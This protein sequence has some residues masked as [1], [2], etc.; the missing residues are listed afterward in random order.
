MARS[1]RDKERRKQRLAITV[2]VIVILLVLAIPAYGYYASFV[3][4]PRELAGRVRD[5]RY[6]MGDLVKQIRTIQAAG[7]YSGEDVDLSSAPFQTLYTLVE[8]E[9]VRQG[10]SSQFGLVVTEDDIQQ[11]LKENF[12]PRDTENVP[13]DQLEREYR[14]NYR[15]FLNLTG[16]SERE[17]REMIKTSIIRNKTRDYLGQSVPTVEESV[18]VAWIFVPYSGQTS[19]QA[20]KERLDKGEEFEKL[21]QEFAQPYDFADDNNG[22]VGWVPRGAFDK[23]LEDAM[24][25]LTPGQVSNLVQTADGSYIVKLI[26]G[27]EVRQVSDT[28]R[29]RLKDQALQNWVN[30]E[31]RKG[32]EEGWLEVNF[33]SD[34]YAW[35]AKQVRRSS[36]P[37]QAASRQQ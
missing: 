3:A 27:P 21:A 31:W 7:R 26:S 36:S 29:E 5:V 9:L 23:A 1:R 22:Y 8:N 6:T 12:Y 34:L 30:E 28:M 24:F 33:S 25:G 10:A 17:Y 19:P 16:L 14:E 4:P 20:I 18:E 13:Q 11:R 35:V 2:G 15:N 32:A 37:A